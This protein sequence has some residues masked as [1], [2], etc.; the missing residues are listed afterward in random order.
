MLTTVFF[1]DWLTRSKAC[2][3]LFLVI[4]SGPYRRSQKSNDF[5]YLTRNFRLRV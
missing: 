5:S 4:F 2:F 1:I 3:S